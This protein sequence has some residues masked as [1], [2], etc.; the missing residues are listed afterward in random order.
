MLTRANVCYN[1][2]M[3]PYTVRVLYGEQEVIY[4]FSSELY[5]IKF[6]ARMGENRRAINHSLSNR[7]SFTVKSDI[8]ADLRLYSSIE[9]RGYLISVDG[10]QIECQENITLDGMRMIFPR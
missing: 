1:L 6:N 9:K 7:F 2:R 4:H 8:I 5:K 10:E 3:T